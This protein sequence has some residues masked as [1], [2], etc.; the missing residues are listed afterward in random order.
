LTISPIT[1]CTVPFRDGQRHLGGLRARLLE[2]L[3]G[4]LRVVRI[5]VQT[6]VLVGQVGRPDEIRRGR[7][8]GA[9]QAGLDDGLAVDGQRDG[10]TDLGVV[11]RGLLRVGGDQVD[12]RRREHE[13]LQLGVGSE[14]GELVGR[15]PLDQVCAATAHGG[16]A[17]AVVGEHLEGQGVEHRLAL[18][19]VVRVA[20]DAQR[21]AR[22]RGSPT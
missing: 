3:L 13:R 19:P 11:E 14:L 5:E 17:S 6:G 21:A 16:H 18:L 12:A 1:D 8:A 10:L 22:D 15:R 4:P 2:E 20:D 7:L 9:E